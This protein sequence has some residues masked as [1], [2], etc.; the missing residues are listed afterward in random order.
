MGHRTESGLTPE[1]VFQT[2]TPAPNGYANSKYLAEQILDYAGQKAQGRNLSISIARVGQ[3][4]GAV[5]ARGLWNKAEWF[6]SM[7]PSSLHVGAVPEDIGSLGRVDWVPVDLVAEVLVALAIGENPDRRTVDV[8]HPH[9][10]HPITWDAI[11]P[12]VFE[13]L[14]TYTGKPLDVVPFRTWIQR[15]RADIAAG[16]STIGEDLQVSLEKNPAAKLL[17]FF[18]DM[19]S[20]SKAE[21]FFDTKRTAERSNKLRA[22]EAVQPEW[23]RKWVKEWLGDAQV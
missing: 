8:F 5:R 22:V 11:R 4:A 2:S 23:L 21:N 7:V 9:N 16:G 20:G 10:L 14:S 12:V 18:D 6:P 1:E 19:A 13:T 15:V 17:N 3:V